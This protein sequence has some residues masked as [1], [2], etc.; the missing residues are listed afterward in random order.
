MENNTH[1]LLLSG[2]QEWADQLILRQECGRFVQTSNKVSICAQLFI[3]IPFYMEHIS[4][5]I[6]AAAFYL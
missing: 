3:L 5:L 4:S 6:L 1:V 2:V